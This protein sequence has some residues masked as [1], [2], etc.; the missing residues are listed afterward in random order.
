MTKTKTY[1]LEL[2]AEELDQLDV[3]SLQRLDSACTR[4]LK[5]RE[6]ARSDR[7]GGDLRLPW[8]A[9]QDADGVWWVHDSLPEDDIDWT[10]EMCKLMAAA[11]ELLDAVKYFKRVAERD[12]FWSLPPGLMSVVDRALRKVKSGI[13]EDV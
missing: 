4:I 11:P 8:S 12:G 10:A 6:Q 2:T 1:T 13:P 3:S 5:L 9:K 7:Q